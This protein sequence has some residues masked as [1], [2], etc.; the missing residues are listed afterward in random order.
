YG[1]ISGAVLLGNPDIINTKA[2]DLDIDIS[3]CD[4][5]DPKNND[6]IEEFAGMFYE[7]RKH[8]GISLNDAK[9]TV[10]QN[11]VFAGL[12]TR[13]QVVHGFIGGSI[14]TTGDTVRAA[15]YTLGLKKGISTLS[16]FFIINVPDCEYGDNGLFLFADCAVIPDPSP[17]QIANITRSTSLAYKN[18]FNKTARC[19]LLSY[20]TKGSAQ[21]SS[22]DKMRKA[23][24]IINEKYADL[25]VDG[26]MQLDSAIVPE[27][28]KRKMQQSPVSGNANVLIFPDLTSGNISYKLA[29]RLAKADAVGPI[30]TGLAYPAN[31][32]SRGCNV[33]DIISVTAVTV[34]Q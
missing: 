23:L 28:A 29:Q 30:L 20:S 32:L 14:N 5:I 11:L 27:I 19:A 21:G 25:I 22:V 6:K 10:T 2:K 16:S 31:D 7:L 9:K 24:L 13:S 34:L 18:L 12:L 33:S 15:L 3:K 8:K 17:R 4:I 1:I 26:E